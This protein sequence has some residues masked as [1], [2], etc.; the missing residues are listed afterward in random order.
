MFLKKFYF[1]G[2]KFFDIICKSYSN[3]NHYNSLHVRRVNDLHPEYQIEEVVNEV[4]DSSAKT[5]RSK[6][7]IDKNKTVVERMCPTGKKVRGVS[8]KKN[9]TEMY[10]YY[11]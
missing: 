9:S 3:N 8:K 11:M 7:L 2:T 5:E 4:L 1:H 6:E 10:V